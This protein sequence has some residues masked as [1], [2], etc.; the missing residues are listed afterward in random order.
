MTAGGQKINQAGVKELIDA[1]YADDG[2]LSTS[3]KKSLQELLR[4]HRDLIESPDA[5][6]K[7]ENFSRMSNA[8]LRDAAYRYA[9]EGGIS[10]IDAR[11][12]QEIAMRDGRIS[13]NEKVTLKALMGY[14]SPDMEPGAR[15]L[16][17]EMAGIELPSPEPTPDIEQLIDVGLPAISGKKYQVSTAGHLTSDG[18]PARYDDQGAEE[19][20]NAAKALAEADGSTLRDLPNTTKTKMI[21]HLQKCFINGQE[22]SV[23]PKVASQQM[24]SGAA[25]TLLSLIENCKPEDGVIK[26]KAID[27]YLDQAG[28][29]PLHG[30]RASMY[31]NMDR[32]ATQLSPEQKLKLDQL[33]NSVVPSHPP[34]DK[35]FSDGKREIN[36]KHYAHHECWI[37]S[38]DP[39][40]QY[41]RKG[42]KVVEQFDE[43]PPR[44]IL[45]RTNEQAPGGAVK[46]RVEV[47]QSHDG[48]F[49]SMDDPDNQV[50]VYTGHSN[51]GGNV[52]EELRLGNEAKGDKLMM[53][54]LCRGK[55]NMFEVANKYPSSHFVTTNQHSYFSAVM[56]MS[57]GMIEGV[58]N[59]KS[60]EEM[61][62]DTP[63][64]MDPNG[65][66][67]YFYP[68]EPRRYAHYDLDRDGIIDGQGAHIDR[69]YNISLREPK[70]AHLDGVMR[71]NDYRPS[72][73]D[74]SKVTHATQFL[75]TLMTYH[76]DKGYNTSTLKKPDMDNFVAGGWFEGPSDQKVRL[77]QL[78]DGRTRVQVNKS[79]AD[80][81]GFVLGAI[82]QSEV[83]KT[84]LTQRNG[85]ELTP[86]DEARAALFAG[87]YL[88]Y[89]Y[90]S[91]NEA[92]AAVRAIARESDN[93]QG[94]T[95]DKVMKA[96]D[97]DGRGYVTDK[98]V[99]ALLAQ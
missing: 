9:Q 84:M 88:A 46:M 69:L 76:V 80:Q 70:N 67:N 74:G 61:K 59:L 18:G 85:G 32:I 29:E 4:N 21:D 71:E 36:V 53:L 90:C 81:S 91:W 19:I 6:T 42:F 38:E 24:R 25:T 87:Q 62:R 79:L 26:Q 31:F 58:I 86:K 30:I 39:I 55:Q 50:I 37:H 75:N 1:A 3:E 48:I 83:V 23:L 60:Y 73:I 5:R 12:L 65:K 28:K 14:Y 66:D 8:T 63:Y 89:M 49:N 27:L 82:I 77:S 51:L 68:H 96:I 72:E 16:V 45:E 17:A 95:F 47:I 13:G 78:P 20:Y 34:Y 64:I 10:E 57:L 56:P 98:Q 97:A 41:Q 15:K 92:H 43:Q 44:W 40:R 11:G 22:D 52:S 54:A 94:I 35:W 93:L 2:K 33:K 99:D 7:L